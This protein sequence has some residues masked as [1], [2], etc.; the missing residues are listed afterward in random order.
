MA[1]CSQGVTRV[2]VRDIWNR[3]DLPDATGSVTTD[4]IAPGDSRFY[5]LSPAKP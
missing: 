2:R 1:L 4:E 3:S 5:L